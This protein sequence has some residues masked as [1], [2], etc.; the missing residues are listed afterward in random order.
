MEFLNTV[1]QS[2]GKTI[3]GRLV[4]EDAFLTFETDNDG[5]KSKIA[6]LM[7]G[8]SG[9]GR[10]N[11]FI[12]GS[13]SAEWYVSYMKALLQ[14]LF[15]TYPNRSI[16]EIVSA[17]IKSAK[18]FVENFEK[19]NNITLEDYEIPS[20]SLAILKQ[21]DTH[22]KLFLLGDT[23]TIIGYKD[24]RIEKIDNPNQNAVQSNDNAVLQKMCKIA[25]AKG[26]DVKDTISEPEI[27]EMLQ[28]NRGKKNKDC[29]GGYWICGTDSEAVNHAV[30][31]TLE[32]S[33]LDSLIL[34]TDG[35]NYSM[36]G[37]DEKEVYKVVKQYG[38][39][40]I[41]R[42]IREAEKQDP[43]ANKYLRFK[44][45]DDSTCIVAYYGREI[46]KPTP[47]TNFIGNK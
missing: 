25:N 33:L 38:T 9:L 26:C 1:C 31:L 2:G 35:F 15:S 16:E 19:E 43:G 6:I 18:Q 46:P 17:A 5:K 13:T 29:P 40:I 41:N 47:S 11:E 23:E 37:Y 21:N 12:K 8:A 32:N 30:T 10:N 20:A 42:Q 27:Q 36:L 3:N 22:S 34:A 24:G 7:D 28:T 39:D 44:Q 14:Q 45:H 4:N